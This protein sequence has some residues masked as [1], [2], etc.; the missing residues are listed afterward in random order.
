MKAKP[1][2]MILTQDIFWYR[3]FGPLTCISIGTC[4][5]SYSRCL[6]IF[7]YMYI[8]GCVFKAI[9]GYTENKYVY[10]WYYIN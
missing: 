5:L 7:L 1:A 6:C 3:S 2:K 10:I 8:G 4:L 9:F